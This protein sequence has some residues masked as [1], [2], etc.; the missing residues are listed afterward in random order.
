MVRSQKGRSRSRVNGGC[1]EGGCVVGGEEGA[2]KV[3]GVDDLSKYEKSVYSRNKQDLIKRFAAAVGPLFGLKNLEKKNVSEINS[4]LKKHLPDPQEQ[5]IASKSQKSTCDALVSAVNS[6]YGKEVVDTNATTEDKCIAVNELIKTMFTGLHSEFV[7]VAKDVRV[8]IKALETLLAVLSSSKKKLLKQLEVSN[9]T[10]YEIENTS[11]LMDE[12]LKEANKQMAHLKN[13]LSIAI[14]PAETSMLVSMK[15]QKVLEGL[16]K[17]FKKASGTQEFGSRLASVLDNVE[18]LSYTTN[19]VEKAL[20]DVGMSVDEYKKTDSLKKLQDKLFD[21]MKELTK[22]DSSFEE[23]NKYMEASELL[24]KNNYR[25]QDIVKTL[26]GSKTYK[27]MSGGGE[28]LTY[29]KRMEKQARNRELV[30]KD[31]TVK[32]NS[33]NRR[34]LSDVE[35][36]VRKVGFSIP[37]SEDLEMFGRQLDKLSTIDSVSG[38]NTARAILGDLNTAE[39]RELKS[40]YVNDLKVVRNAAKKVDGLKEI[41]NSV[42][43]LLTLIDEY[44][45]VITKIRA[46]SVPVKGG[47]Q[48][49]K[50]EAKKRKEE[51]KEKRRDAGKRKDW[52]ARESKRESKREEEAKKARG[53]GGIGTPTPPPTAEI[54]ST[55]ERVERDVNDAQAAEYAPAPAP[56]PASPSAPAP[57]PAPASPSVPAPAPAPASPSANDSGDDDD[58]DDDG[59]DGDDGDDTQISA[60]EVGDLSCVSQ[61]AH[62]T[63]NLQ[64]VMRNFNYLYKSAKVRDNLKRMT[65][66]QESYNKKYEEVLGDAIGQRLNSIRK[67]YKSELELI[68]KSG[69]TDKTKDGMKK[70]A[71][72]HKTAREKLYKT[73]E[74]IDM[75]LGGF[76]DG[77]AKNPDDVGSLLKMLDT[78]SLNIKWYTE[79]SGDEFAM[80]FDSFPRMN[81]TK[82]PSKSELK[83]DMKG[84]DINKTKY[85]WNTVNANGP[86]DINKPVHVNTGL[87]I[88]KD[89]N[90]VVCSVTVLKNI[91]SLFTQIGK[92]FGGNNLLTKCPLSPSQIY[93]NLSEYLTVGAF[94]R[95]NDKV[96]MKSIG[97]VVQDDLFFTQTLQAMVA[98]VLTCVGTHVMLY[99]PRVDLNDVNPSHPVRQI[100]GGADSQVEIID[101]AVELYVRLPLLMEFYRELHSI[102]EPI[103]D[104]AKK[105]TMLP[106]FNNVWAGLVNIIYEKAA[107]VKNGSYSTGQSQSLIREINTIYKKYKAV[108]PKD[109]VREVVLGLVA[110]MN[111]RYGVYCK[112]EI[113]A[114]KSNRKMEQYSKDDP[115]VATNYEI[116]DGEGEPEY[117]RP[118]PSDNYVEFTPSGSDKD[119]NS[120]GNKNELSAMLDTFRNK[121]VKALTEDD[122]AE[123]FGNQ[124]YSFND[125]IRQ[126]KESLKSASSS[127][128]LSVMTKAIQSS[129]KLT[130]AS[131]SKMLVVHELVLAPLTLVDRTVSKL[132]QFCS[133]V[134]TNPDTHNAI[135]T[136]F[137]DMVKY[138]DISVDGKNVN[139]DADNVVSTCERLLKNTKQAYSKLLPLIPND[140]STEI[141]SMF[142]DVEDKMDM[143]F[144]DKTDVK[145][146]NHL[147]EQLTT[148]LR[149]IGEDDMQN[150][151]E[152]KIHDTSMG[153]AA[154]PLRNAA[155]KT[156]L[157]MSVDKE[158]AHE[159][160]S[161]VD[162]TKPFTDAPAHGRLGDTSVVTKFN[163]LLD[164]YIGIVFDSGSSCVYENTLSGFAS[165]PAYPAVYSGMG[166]HFNVDVSNVQDRSPIEAASAYAIKRLLTEKSK[167]AKGLR[168]VK[169][170]VMELPEYYKES[171]RCNL[172]YINKKFVALNTECKLLKDLTNSAKPTKITFTDSNIRGSGPDMP[173]NYLKDYSYTAE[174]SDSR[175]YLND[176]LDKI[177]DLSNSLMKC[178]D[179][180]LKDLDN[181]PVFGEVYKNSVSDYRA[182]HGIAPVAPLSLTLRSNGD[183]AR[184][185]RELLTPGMPKFKFNYATR[186]V[187]CNK[188]ADVGNEI[189]TRYNAGATPDMQISESLCKTICTDFVELVTTFTYDKGTTLPGLKFTHVG[190]LYN[191]DEHAD[192]SEPP[193]ISSLVNLMEGGNQRDNIRKYVSCGSDKPEHANTREELRKWNILDLNIVP[194]NFHALRRE[195][196]LINI[197]NYAYTFKNMVARKG[198]DAMQFG[199]LLTAPYTSILDSDSLNSLMVGDGEF[200]RPRFLSDQVWTKTLLRSLYNNQNVHNTNSGPIGVS[201]IGRVVVAQSTGI[202]NSATFEFKWDTRTLNDADRQTVAKNRMDTVLVR[203]MFMIVLMHMFMRHEMKEELEKVD[204]PVVRKLEA[205]NRKVTEFNRLEGPNTIDD[206][207]TR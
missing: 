70:Y 122:D 192:G 48:D 67:D 44:S 37:L 2:P 120:L 193:S 138:M 127:D 133:N 125:S 185:N 169:S 6:I 40:N 50:K 197:F 17:K 164:D 22:K 72:L 5:R 73:L 71:K 30:R 92:K 93:K 106:E 88:I 140:T 99:K 156:L 198:L 111:R 59:D 13:M 10:K 179:T 143:R 141:K 181:T 124:K 14:T 154:R 3:G 45:D 68:D 78:L 194:V 191:C 129:G 53:W 63:V 74:A 66:D 107:H 85:Y 188:L 47:G 170:D 109:T 46:V 27:N 182:K 55:D 15:K 39:A 12:V 146:V 32:F 119:T 168:W 21:K 100:L 89:T 153:E 121:V 166:L 25:H 38:K 200:G 136:W 79:S 86:G 49:R 183:Y 18:V 144:R 35:T 81:G 145:G 104:D 23:L 87:N 187:M 105:I 178:I 51:A 41:A 77:L 196:P 207:L 162:S 160:G 142:R 134:D 7:S 20:K 58:G 61:V 204:A 83:D 60:L 97:G 203:N 128:R 28:K 82:A 42:D 163:A 114:W 190:S 56:A 57:A 205:L 1:T 101:D 19:V 171:L 201:G 189:M 172:C 113:E 152:Q 117:P 135:W 126:V 148:H 167:S 54:L 118:S 110:E 95:D 80:I 158:S 186:S 139:V 9:A 33:A 52:E 8:R 29:D 62:S 76:S 102:D 149:S 137:N 98:K 123:V 64:K 175:S 176:A 130:N 24:R 132:A 195:I 206:A 108:K 96:F 26:G 103:A 173:P 65:F 177:V 174:H 43:N 199:K 180:T 184:N 34:I 4:V 94:L 131:G 150:L 90:K 161:R 84:T 155:V 75:Y 202:N 36:A 116:L 69:S 147:S 16:F 157:E 159:L 11:W 115:S 151:L 91:V 31:F 165:G 112:E